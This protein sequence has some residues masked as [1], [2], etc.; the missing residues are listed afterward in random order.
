M[1]KLL[2]QLGLAA[3]LAVLGSQALFTWFGA[4]QPAISPLLI[5]SLALIALLAT[6]ALVIYIMWLALWE[7]EPNPR[8]RLMAVG[9]RYAAPAKVASQLGPLVL[10]FVFLAAFGTFKVMI[11]R[12]HPFA[13]D[14]FL[15]DLD[16]LVFRTDPWRLTHAIIGPVGTRFLDIAYGMWFP[17]WTGAVIYFS[18]FASDDLKRRFFLSFFA[19]WSIIG[20]VLATILSSA[21]PC[22]LGLIGHPYAA[23]FSGLLPLADAPWNEH[24][25]ALLAKAYQ[26]GNNGLAMGISAMPSVH[27]A[28]AALLMFAARCYHRAAY[29]GATTF[30]A[31]I[32]LGSVHFG[33]HYV[34]DGIAG[35]LGAWLIWKATERRSGERQGLKSRPDP[36]TAKIPTTE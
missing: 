7:R 22:F 27:V 32:F 18:L 11:P 3:L 12:I 26:T 24:A 2:T 34:S 4:V 21:G 17:A 10:T 16:R 36:A 8:S 20:I 5:A 30:Y 29:I 33:W 25:Q 19:V 13:L 23:R 15:S 1:S 31:L 6:L 28:V 14:G 35:T 9:K